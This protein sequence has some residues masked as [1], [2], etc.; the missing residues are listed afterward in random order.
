MFRANTK[1]ISEAEQKLVGKSG[2]YQTAVNKLA[3][4]QSELEYGYSLLRTNDW[5]NPGNVR[6]SDQTIYEIYQ[7]KIKNLKQEKKE[8]IDGM[9]KQIKEDARYKNLS[10][11][12]IKHIEEYIDCYSAFEGFYF[13][14]DVINKIIAKMK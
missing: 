14:D 11:D 6:K 7:S 9:L 13:N 12:C 2:I 5:F 1:P 4:L 3:N 8:V 10:E